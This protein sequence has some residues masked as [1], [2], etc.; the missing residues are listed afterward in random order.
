MYEPE[1]LTS[2][3][4]EFAS[5]KRTRSAPMPPDAP[6]DREYREH[7]EANTISSAEWKRYAG[8]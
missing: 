6:T 5:V 7:R 4:R 2:A 1:N 3:E 8:N